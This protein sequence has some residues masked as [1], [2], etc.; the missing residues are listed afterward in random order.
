M[1]I[2]EQ[3]EEYRRQGKSGWGLAWWLAWEFAQRYHI[4]HGIQPTVITHEGLGYYGIALVAVDCKVH[5]RQYNMKPDEWNPLGRFSSGGNAENWMKDSRNHGT[6]EL[7]DRCFKA[8]APADQLL[9]AAIDH[10]D[11]PI[12]PI[13]SHVGCF[14]HRQGASYLLIF[15]LVT[16]LAL[17]H[18]GE[19]DIMMDRDILKRLF[20]DLDPS[21]GQYGHWGHMRLLGNLHPGKVVLA[22]DGRVLFPKNETSLW[23]RYMRGESEFELKEQLWN[24]I[25]RTSCP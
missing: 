12:K 15:S 10:F 1:T 22:P 5:F 4:S 19:F 14:H 9:K 21:W 24:W 8:N 3:F 25:T 7:D 16:R 6:L 13:N 2:R 17:E 23:E 11:F 20:S 18:E